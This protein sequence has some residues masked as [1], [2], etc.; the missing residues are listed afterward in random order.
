MGLCKLDTRGCERIGVFRPIFRFIS[1]TVQ[2][3]A[4]VRLRWKA[5]KN[6][7]AVYRMMTFPMTFN[8]TFQG[9]DIFE[10]T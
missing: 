8:E 2:D 1:K 4:V 7:Y 10:V 5:N 3:T 9:H 6:S